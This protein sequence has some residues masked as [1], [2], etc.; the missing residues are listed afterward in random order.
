MITLL[1]AEAAS[2]INSPTFF[3]SSAKAF[4]DSPS[5]IAAFMSDSVS[6]NPSNNPFVATPKSWDVLSFKVAN[7]PLNV[8]DC[9][10]MDL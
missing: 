7:M 3:A 9:A 8:C 10:S 1:I 2:P 4:A 6:L 5:D